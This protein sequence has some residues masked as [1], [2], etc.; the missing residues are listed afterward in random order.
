MTQMLDFDRYSR[1]VPFPGLGEAGQRRLAEA[2]VLLVGCGGLGSVQA[3]L[4]VRAGV[5]RLR[6]VDC[7]AVEVQN[8]HRQIL[9]DEP[10]AGRPKAEVAAAKLR[11]ANSAV[12]VEGVVARFAA[13]NAEEL[14]RGADLILD[15]T[16]N[17]ATRF[18]IND[19]AVKHGLPWIYGACVGAEGRMLPIIPHRTACLRCIWDEPPA[20]PTCA[21]VGVL[22]PMVAMVASFQALAAMQVLIGRV[23][24]L[25]TRMLV[26]DGWSWRMRRVDVKAAL[27]RGDCRCCKQG[28]YEYLR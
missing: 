28:A 23:D 22:G 18:V 9:Y 20:H 11:Q 3:T 19:V 6:I 17:A 8:L 5:G 26:I 15:G 7:D 25:D 21:T 2:C 16:D 13:A 1:Q 14:A 4:L 12:Q 10:D 24:D 27:E